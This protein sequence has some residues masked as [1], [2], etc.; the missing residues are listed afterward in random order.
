V[1]NSG[2]IPWS[3]GG[4]ANWYIAQAGGYGN[5]ATRKKTAV[6]KGNT[7]AWMKPDETDIE[8]GDMIF[9]PHEPLVRLATTTDLITVASAVVGGLT[10]ILSLIITLSR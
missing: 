4:D 8:P 1:N 5:S 2:F 9:V 6:I 7:R 10:G 3:E